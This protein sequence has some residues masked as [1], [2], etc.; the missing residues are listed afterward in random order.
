MNIPLGIKSSCTVSWLNPE[1]LISYPAIGAGSKTSGKERIE[2]TAPGPITSS[3]EACGS[4]I[5]L[6][7]GCEIG[8]R[9][10]DGDG[11]DFLEKEEGF[12]EEE[13]EEGLREPPPTGTLRRT[14]P[15]VQ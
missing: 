12:L 13:E 5:G 6:G 11:D 15:R 1:I 2:G 8:D 14:P 9:D 4:A 3:G 7:F 10:G